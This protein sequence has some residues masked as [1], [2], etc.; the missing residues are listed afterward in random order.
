MGRVAG[1]AVRGIFVAGLTM[2]PLIL[3]QTPAEHVVQATLVLALAAGAFTAM[4]YGARVPAMIELRGAPGYNRAR[5]GVLAL[6]LPLGA[7]ACGAAG[8]SGP[9]PALAEAVGLRLHATLGAAPSP[10]AVIDLALPP[11]AAP[12]RARMVGAVAALA[13]A[14]AALCVAAYALVLARG[15]WPRPAVDARLP[16]AQAFGLWRDLP[17]YA[18]PAGCDLVWRLR[19]DGRVNILLGLVLPYLLPPLAA[20]LGRLHGVSVLGSD[21]VLTWA[22]ALWAVLPACLILRGLALLRLAAAIAAR[23]RRLAQPGG[24]AEAD[25]L[26][27]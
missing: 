10:L 24:T 18:A 1:G 14:S 8:A 23:R 13:F 7:L 3:L 21:L 16:E 15:A 22:M 26:P 5:V 25:F 2:L 27:V 6:A 19:R 11:D 12:G 9:L 4:E 20:V 17:A